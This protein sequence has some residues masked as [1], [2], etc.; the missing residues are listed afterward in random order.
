MR[1]KTFQFILLFVLILVFPCAC[2]SRGNAVSDTKQSSVSFL[3][4]E[5]AE[6]VKPEYA[7]QFQID[8]YKEGYRRFT[9]GGTQQYLLVPKDCPTPLGLPEEMVVIQGPIEHG[10]LA[11]TSAMDF[12]C[13]LQVLDCLDFVSIKEKD[14]YIE[15]AKTAMSSGA[16]Q[17]AGSYSAP[18]MELLMTGGCDIA[19]ENT[20]ILHT[21]QIKEQLENNGIA[22][23]V[24]RSSYESH[25]LGRFEWIK[26]Y[27]YLFGKEDEANAFFDLSISKV[28]D[29]LTEENT[30]KTVAFF[31]VTS[32]HGVSVRKKNDYIANMIR[33]A[34]G[35]YVVC[36]EDEE[37]NALATTTIQMEVF[38]EKAKDADIL[39]YNS[40]IDGELQSMDDLLK[41]D[42]IF[43]DFKAV[44][45]KKVYCSGRN[46]FQE[47][48]CFAQMMEDFHYILTGQDESCVYM[49]HLD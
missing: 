25:P 27:G 31:Y 37:E 47:T 17:Y 16:L 40:T 20:M 39:I 23:I 45:E 33:L 7:T 11:S 4:L 14:W 43:A 29:I 46:M 26:F 9:V 38:Y 21:P 32:N 35:E 10:Y 22:V 36:D 42:E 15:E 2:K 12:I 41:K 48:T 49:Y 5:I 1:K 28:E 8:L 30:G 6:T 34:G 18:D 24:E 3:D 19:I 13:T 44:K